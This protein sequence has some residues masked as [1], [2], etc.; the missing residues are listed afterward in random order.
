MAYD[1][2]WSGESIED[3]NITSN[4]CYLDDRMTTHSIEYKVSGVGTVTIAVY[5]SISGQYW[6]NN[7]NKAVGVGAT[8]GPDSDGQD[9][10]PMRLK[11]GELIRFKATATGAVV[12]TL[13]FSQK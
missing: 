1:M 5:T 6:I 2:V 12:L 4:L 13:Y 11:P 9:T 8:S 7:G 3:T 10:V